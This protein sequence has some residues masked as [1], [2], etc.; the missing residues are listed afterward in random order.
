MSQEVKHNNGD[1]V[2]ILEAEGKAKAFELINKSFVGNAQLLKQY[3]MTQ[4]S[5]E[6]NSKII[7]TKEGINPQIIIGALPVIKKNKL[8]NTICFHVQ[9]CAE[10]YLKALMAK[11]G[12]EIV[13]T[14]NLV[15][16][17]EKLQEVEP[18]IELNKD[19]LRNLNRYDIKFRYPGDEATI[20]EARNAVKQLKDIREIFIE[21]LRH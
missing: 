6:T 1:C 20:S 16:L 17:L 2:L 19:I 18:K 15:Y 8:P 13:K 3:E 12:I 7:I 5:L 21:R 9:Q 10:K 14:H 4:A 11:H